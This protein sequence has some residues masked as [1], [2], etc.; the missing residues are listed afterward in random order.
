[1]GKQDFSVNRLFEDKEIF[2]DF[3]NG[4]LFQGNQVLCADRL[5]QLSAGG[6]VV[7]VNR[8]GKE[9]ALLRRRDVCMKADTRC[10]SVQ[11]VHWI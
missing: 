3:M 9:Q 5:E 10:L 2:A 6:G 1:M 8:K 7:Y 11:T 4:S